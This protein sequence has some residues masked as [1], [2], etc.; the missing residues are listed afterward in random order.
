MSDK[1]K[2]ISRIIIFSLIFLV[3][4]GIAGYSLGVNIHSNAF[5]ENPDFLNNAPQLNESVKAEINSFFQSTTDVDEINTYC[6]SNPMYCMEYCRTIN[7]S[8]EVCNKINENFRRGVP[9][10]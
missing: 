7:P 2:G 5:K 8:F 10:R 9:Q 4:G 3:V 6:Q 1:N